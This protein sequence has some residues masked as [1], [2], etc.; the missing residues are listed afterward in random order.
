MSVLLQ[1]AKQTEEKTVKLSCQFESD[2]TAA[3]HGFLFQS[4]HLKMIELNL[5]K[6]FPVNVDL[7][8]INTLLKCLNWSC[9]CFSVPASQ[10]R[11]SRCPAGR[12][13]D[14]RPPSNAPQPGHSV[15][16]TGTVRG[17]RASLQTGERC[18]HLYW[19]SKWLQSVDW[20]NASDDHFSTGF[21]RPGE[22]LRP[23]P[24]RRSHHAEYTSARVQVRTVT[25]TLSPIWDMWLFH[26]IYFD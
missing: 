13:R 12:L 11:R 2:H 25:V 18:F 1:R 17:R 3:K 26:L 24:P 23:H 6:A 4:D 7:P 5:G 22:V 20:P 10:Q 8:V 16:F 19:S 9:P 21:G 15:R 14:S